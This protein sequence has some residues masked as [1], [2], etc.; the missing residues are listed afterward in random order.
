MRTALDNLQI[1]TYNCVKQCRRCLANASARV[2]N[3]HA[4]RNRACFT[5]AFFAG[6]LSRAV[7][8][9]HCL[10]R[11]DHFAVQRISGYFNIGISI[12]ILG[13]VRRKR[14]NQPK[15]T[16]KLFLGGTRLFDAVRRSTADANRTAAHNEQPC[17]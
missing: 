11:L 5:I 3:Q 13:R 2:I 4:A 15:L 9:G 14:R 12:L 6:S 1:S 16:D 7:V 10:P 17:D 8:E